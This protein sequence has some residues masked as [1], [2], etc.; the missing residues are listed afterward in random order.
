[1]SVEDLL[2]LTPPPTLTPSPTPPPTDTPQP[3]STNTPEPTAADTAVP[4]PA[5]TPT[6]IPQRTRVGAASTPLPTAVPLENDNT[7]GSS[8]NWLL[9]G[10]GVLL[11]VGIGG[12]IISRRKA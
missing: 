2:K 4:P 12:F 9:I 8:T 6:V 10:A 11:L 5:D 1:M 3:T 7:G